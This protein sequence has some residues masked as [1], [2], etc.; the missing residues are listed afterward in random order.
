M[1]GA[2]DRLVKVWDYQTKACIQTLDG[3]SHNI[4]TVCFHPE[5]PLILTGSEDGTVKLWHRWVWGCA[6][7]WFGV[8]ASC[9]E[10]GWSGE[11]EV[12]AWALPS[13]ISRA[14]L[15]VCSS[16]RPCR[17]CLS[18][19]CALTCAWPPV[20]PPPV[21][22]HHVPPGEHAQLRHGA[23]VGCGLR[24]GLQQRGRGVS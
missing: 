23:G 20:L 19:L 4:S 9:G 22:Q 21:P 2:D 16:L 11:A 12:R 7:L 15:P 17:C 6:C 1:S 3:H 24:Q 18:S 5:L 8:C 14:T 13:A 10:K